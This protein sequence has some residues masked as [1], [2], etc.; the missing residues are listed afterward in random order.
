MDGA[1]QG[2]E[3]GPVAL[4]QIQTEQQLRGLGRARIVEG[5]VAVVALEFLHPPRVLAIGV[6]PA[7]KAVL[8]R[9]VDNVVPAPGRMLAPHQRVGGGLAGLVKLLVAR[10]MVGVEEGVA[11]GPRA[12]RLNPDH[13]RCRL[14]LAPAAREVGQ[15]GPDIAAVDGRLVRHEGRGAFHGGQDRGVVRRGSSGGSLCQ[16]GNGGERRQGCARS[17]DGAAR[18]GRRHGELRVVS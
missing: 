5:G 2:S 9:R 6:V 11:H 3:I 13:G 1:L 15:I 18:Q 8:A 14:Q 10:C 17:E 16:R 7:A 12:R 4:L